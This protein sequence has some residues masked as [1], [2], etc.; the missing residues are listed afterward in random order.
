MTVSTRVTRR[1]TR[2]SARRCRDDRRDGTGR[3]KRCGVP[4]EIG[5]AHPIALDRHD[6]RAC[7]TPPARPRTA[8]RRRTGRAPG[9]RRPPRPSR[10]DEV[11]HEESVGLEERLRV[12]PK[13][14]HPARARAYRTS[15]NRSPKGSPASSLPPASSCTAHPSARSPAGSGASALPDR[16]HVVD[17][18]RQRALAAVDA[19]GQLDRLDARA[20]ARRASRPP[21][22]TDSRAASLTCPVAAASHSVCVPSR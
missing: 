18:D 2:G 8:R 9:R 21:M 10:R 22:T 3:G 11:R 19:L 4:L 14:D 17:G 6:S 15:A 13:R 16:S 20:G 7:L 12:T 5:A 1:R